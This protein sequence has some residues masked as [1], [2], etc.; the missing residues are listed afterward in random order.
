MFKSVIELLASDEQKAYYLPLL[1]D[2]L[3]HGCYA[4]TEFGHGSDVSMLETV[5]DFDEASDS[6]V[7]NSPTITSGK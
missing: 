7:V 4:Q 3:I 2:F 1:Q 5:A 6:F